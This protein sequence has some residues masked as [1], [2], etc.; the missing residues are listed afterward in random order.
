MG[1]GGSRS[2][3]EGWFPP[4]RPWAAPPGPASSRSRLLPPPRSPPLSPRASP[5]GDGYYLAVGG[6]AAQH[7]WS[8]IRTVLQ[9]R[10]FRCQLIDRSEDLGLVSVQGPAR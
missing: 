2:R 8:H 10:R 5:A 3:E 1:L 6:A 7:S 9:D 4:Q